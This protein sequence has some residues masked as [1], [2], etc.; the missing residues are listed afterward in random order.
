[1]YL[2]VCFR[3]IVANDGFKLKEF[4]VD[5]KQCRKTTLAPTFGGPATMLCPLVVGE[6][7][8]HF[9]Y[10]T[11]SKVIGL[12]CLPLT[13]DPSKVSD[14]YTRTRTH[15]HTHCHHIRVL[16]FLLVLYLY[17]YLCCVVLPLSNRM[18][19]LLTLAGDG[20]GGAPEPHIRSHRFLG[21]H[22]CVLIRGT[23]PLCE[24]VASGHAVSGPPASQRCVQHR[25]LPLFT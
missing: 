21:R 19:S 10:S 12:G 17:L 5:S 1:M 15:T 6:T 7:V 20:T 18:T 9:A 4:N 3:F 2:C 16:V 13:G 22:V 25:P 23:G 8:S 24:H 14:C 11:G